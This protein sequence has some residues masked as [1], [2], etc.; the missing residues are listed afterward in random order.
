[1]ASSS[2]ISPGEKGKI[3]AKID[4]SQRRGMLFKT[5]DVLSNDPKRPKATLT[6]KADIK[7][8]V[9]TPASPPSH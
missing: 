4:T 1:M 6:L 3:T 9:T 8:P 5:I 2:H 7:E